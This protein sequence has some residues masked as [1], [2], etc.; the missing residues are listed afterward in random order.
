MDVGNP[1]K[2]RGMWWGYPQTRT[3]E[4][5]ICEQQAGDTQAQQAT[6]PP[7]RTSQRRL[8]GGLAPVAPSCSTDRCLS[9][10]VPPRPPLLP[11]ALGGACLGTP[12]L[13]IV[14][15]TDCFVPKSSL[16]PEALRG[17]CL[18]MPALAIVCGTD[19]FVPKS[20]LLP[21]ALGGAC[22]GTPALATTLEH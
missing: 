13:A 12:A 19:C 5:H 1:P 9:W 6:S 3:K 20:S 15:G 4:N 18:G 11:E 7:S 8:F 10:Y 2:A 22:L 14:C 16:L 21:E 17:A